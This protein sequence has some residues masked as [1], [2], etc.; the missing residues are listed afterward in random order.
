M[1]GAISKMIDLSPEVVTV[2]TLTAREAEWK[3]LK[4]GEEEGGVTRGDR[5]QL[6]NT[7][8]RVLACVFMVLS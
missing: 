4:G 8:Q 3:E 6:A 2:S 1:W 5:E 7:Q